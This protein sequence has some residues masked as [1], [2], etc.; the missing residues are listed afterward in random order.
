MGTGVFIGT[1]LRSRINPD[2]FRNL[3]IG[4]L[5]LSGLSAIANAIFS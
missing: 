3:V 2:H 1:R 4:L 5:T